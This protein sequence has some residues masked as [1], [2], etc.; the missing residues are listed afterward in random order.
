MG[1]PHPFH[2]AILPEIAMRFTL[3][4]EPH[5]IEQLPDSLQDQIV[6][7]MPRLIQRERA[8]ITRAEMNLRQ[9]REYVEQ[10]DTWLTNTFYRADDG[11]VLSPKLY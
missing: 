7:Q 3:A 11:K 2:P 1:L 10:F 6:Y 4:I 5:Q 8:R 9:Q